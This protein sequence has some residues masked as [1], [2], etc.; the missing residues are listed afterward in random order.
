[1]TE[2]RFP[3]TKAGNDGELFLRRF[4]A[5]IGSPCLRQRV[6]GA[7]ITGVGGHGVHQTNAS[8][9][10]LMQDLKRA[11]CVAA[12]PPPPPL[13]FLA[14]DPPPPVAFCPCRVFLLG[15]A[16]EQAVSVCDAGRYVLKPGRS[17]EYVEFLSRLLCPDVG[18]CGTLLSHID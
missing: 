9:L 18:R 14:A 15:A 17:P 12:Y 16:H 6:H 4:C 13:A 11:Q 2:C 5:W 7:P 3:F 10:R 8:N 1:M